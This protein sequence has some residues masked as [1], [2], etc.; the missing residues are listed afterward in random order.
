V[1]SPTFS[2]ALKSTL[3]KVVKSLADAGGLV[4]ID[5]DGSSLNSAKLLQAGNAIAWAQTHYS[6]ASNRVIFD[7][8]FEVAAVTTSDPAQYTSMDITGTL[9]D[10]FRPMTQVDVYDYSGEHAGT[11]KLGDF[12]VVS[13]D[14]QPMQSNEVEG[15]RAVT[16]V[17]K[18]VR[19]G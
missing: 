12:S 19:Y 11:S 9:L 10:M 4:Y 2:L 8:A 7:L 17:A 1:T 14:V 6:Q 5:L 16:V 13:A 18:G 3:D 15:L